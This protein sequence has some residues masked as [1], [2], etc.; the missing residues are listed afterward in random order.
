MGSVLRP[1]G[2]GE[3]AVCEP[4]LYVL[5]AVAFTQLYIFAR[6]PL[7]VHLKIVG[8]VCTLYLN[9]TDFIKI[10]QYMACYRKLISG[11]LHS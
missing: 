6:F 1:K 9:K 3:P 11:P 10:N 2:H 7:V 4:L 8:L 5:I